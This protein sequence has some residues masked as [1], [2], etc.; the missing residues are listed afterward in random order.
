MKKLSINE[1]M[2]ARRAHLRPEVNIRPNGELVQL[3][4]LGCCGARVYDFNVEHCNQNGICFH[5]ER[6]FNDGSK[7]RTPKSEDHLYAMY[8]HITYLSAEEISTI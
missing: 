6:P 2:A 3:V 4:M 1:R 7:A 5:C 8:G